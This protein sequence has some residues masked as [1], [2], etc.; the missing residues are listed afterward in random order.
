MKSILS[1]CKF[2]AVFTVLFSVSYSFAQQ[3]SS[4]LWQEI[5]TAQISNQQARTEWP[6][7]YRLWSL[8]L[9]TMRQFLSSAPMENLTSGNV[10]IY[11]IQLPTP[12]GS[13]ATFTLEETRM[14]SEAD[15]QA[16]PFIRT[17]VIKGVTDVRATG[18]IDVTQWGFH[19]LVL[20]H[21][22]TTVIDPFALGDTVNYLCFH[23]EN[24]LRDNDFYCG[25]EADESLTP[26]NFQQL[27]QAAYAERSNGTQLRSYRLALACTGEYAAYYGG[28]VSGAYSGMVTS[29]NRV[30]VVYEK[31]LAIRLN[32]IANNTLLV[33]TNAS[34][35]PYTNNSGT[36]LLG[37]NQ[38]NVTNVIGGA[39]YDI[40]HIFS[41]GGGGVAS[42]QSVCSSTNKARGVTGSANPIGDAF[43]IDYVAHEIGHQFGGNHT[44]NATTGSCNGNR[45]AGAAYE[46]G[47][48]STIMAYAGICTATNNLQPN[49]DPYFHAKSFEEAIIF[50][51]TGSGNGCAVK[52]NTNNDPPVINPG[53][54]YTIPFQTPFKLTGSATDPNNDPL[55]Y[56]WEQYNLGNA[57]NWNA[58]AGDAPIFRSFNPDTVPFRIFPKMS[59]IVNN[60]TTIGELL[61]TYART[62]RFK[63][64]ARDNKVAG[65]G[66]TNI[67]STI[68]VTVINTTTPF[69]VTNPNTA[70][71]WAAGS[72]QTVTW[73]VSNTTASPITCAN[74]KISLSLDGGY[75]Y[76]NV[77]IASTPNDGSEVITVPNNPSTT[78]RVKVEAVGNIFFDISNTNFTITGTVGPLTA[79]TTQSPS[80][81]TIC[82]GQTFTL[83]FTPNGNATAG[84]QFIAELSNAAGSFAAP[85]T[86][87]T[88]TSTNTSSMSVTIPANTPLGTGYRIRVRSTNPAVIGSNNGTNLTVGTVPG[89]AGVVS[90]L[91]TVCAGQSGVVYSLTAV[92]GATSYSWNLPSGVVVTNG[93]N[94][95][96]IT[97]TF[98]S[99]FTTGQIIA[100]P[101]NACGNGGTS[102][103]LTVSGTSA[104]LQFTG[105]KS[106][107][108]GDAG[109]TFTLNP[110]PGTPTY[111]WSLPSGVTIA[112][113]SGTNSINA[114]FS[115]NAVTGLVKV[116]VSGTCG[117]DSASRL[118]TIGGTPSAPTISAQ[119]NLN[120]C[121]GDSVALSAPAVAGVSYQWQLNNSPINGA[122][123]TSIVA[124][125]S[126]SYILAASYP[127][128]PD[129]SFV[130]NT[131]A[132]VPSN[133]CTGATSTITISGL[134]TAY[135]A[136]AISMLMNMTHGYVGDLAIFLIS[137]QGNILG[138]CDRTG[139][140]N[141]SGD[142]LTNTQFTDFAANVMPTTGAPYTGQYLPWS[143]VFTSCLTSTNTSFT[144]LGTNG[145]INPNGTWTLRV[146]DRAGSNGGTL[147][148]WR[149]NF[150]EVTG[151]V[152][153]SNPIV[154]NS[155]AFPTAFNVTGG[156]SVCSSG[157]GLSVTLSG[158][159]TGVNYQ[160]KRNGAN[161]N[162]PIAGT[163]NALVFSGLLQ[164]GT[165]TIEG[166]NAL[167]CSSTMN[168]SASIL[169]NVS[170][171]WYQD[172]DVDGFGNPA[173]SIQDCA[174]PTGYVGNNTDCNDN[175]V[176]IN[177]N[178]L[179]YLDADG[180]LYYTGSPVQQCVSPGLGYTTTIITG[181]DCNDSN[182]AI[183][184]TATETC[185]GL[186]DNCNN[187]ID[188]GLTLTYYQDSDGDTYG[189]P[190]VSVQSCTALTGYVLN[191]LDC[192]DTNAAVNPNSV[193]YLDADGDLYYTGN[194]VTQCQSPGNGYTI[195]VT[196]GGDCNDNNA[197]VHPT[198]TEICNG[199][200]DNCNNQTDEGLTTT[201]YQ[202]NDGDTF[203]NPSVTIQACAAPNGYVANSLDCDDTNPSINPGSVWYLDADGD[204]YYIG[205]SV[206]QCQSP[207]AGCTISVLGG[208]DCNDANPAIN[209]GASEICNGIDENCNNLVDEGV[210]L[211][212]YLDADNDTYGNSSVSVQDC[213]APQGYVVDNTDCDDN[214]PNINP[215]SVEILGNGIDDDCNTQTSDLVSIKDDIAMLSQVKIYPNPLG[216]EN[217]NIEMSKV[218]DP[219]VLRIYD[220]A[221]RLVFED[222]L[223]AERTQL[224]LS[225]LSR[226][227]YVLELGLNSSVYRQ[228]LI[229]Q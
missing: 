154:V 101:V 15:A 71:T 117:L 138:L 155:A 163:G 83:N 141:N 28:T 134:P 103:A 92:S 129:T 148:N 201:F 217:L 200:D 228:R 125:Q 111:T 25:T 122:T 133:S 50:S 90:G 114:N 139:N 6:T 206:T 190:S 173:V 75:N 45:S 211:T 91:T 182:A 197:A 9:P 69:R 2:L 191:N 152:A 128:L 167:G 87:G 95:N 188:E 84:N 229:L 80:P 60:T 24:M 29:I 39:N 70:L 143:P 144:S 169:I 51:V 44:F 76:P 17:Y 97:L 145:F 164:D 113:G 106:V 146:F 100:T 54:N 66:V 207:G 212:F 36:T 180:D 65:G 102:S 20:G 55:T 78:A 10:P 178:T 8:D 81:T 189:N 202:D 105:P 209:P 213:A 31:E 41:T 198:A 226:G 161:L 166:T 165:Y 181:G 59:D 185:N 57:S 63:F 64:T 160:L 43:D 126:G 179:W 132:N 115:A 131:T 215:S 89:N 195:T 47:S 48:G 151:C 210:K 74:V 118:V 38:T 19:G 177:P 193:W 98:P 227:V 214:N 224:E 108:A 156:G 99:N 30:N 42:L 7:D 22:Y 153:F 116:R 121:T 124:K 33:Y 127:S 183:H 196:G 37:E 13:M 208:G 32:L 82:Q 194:A 104:S 225:D 49:S 218:I 109:V 96:S 142:N 171:T 34:T 53:L 120:F 61:P 135:P 16:F 221:G 119:G 14:I 216:D 40:G 222:V 140:T 62:L 5:S 1:R 94:T 123:T 220:V 184:P 168:G 158:S 46:P 93:A 107:C 192:D 136:S 205:N 170:Q 72:T 85:I 86:I 157:T 175:N 176:N 186:D 52:T 162:T 150:A 58:P 130:N 11:Y 79:I 219:V 23:K 112:T 27:L 159:Q 110:Q 68:A 223:N 56:C 203:G 73:D 35:D 147:L 88:I 187:Q 4:S 21:N 172:L 18:R 67:D 77:L 204:F 3:N 149:L 137:P 174:A 12:S 199:I 26:V